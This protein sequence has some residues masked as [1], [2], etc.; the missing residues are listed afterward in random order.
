MWNTQK[1]HIF[2]DTNVLVLGVPQ[3]QLLTKTV[4]VDG[5]PEKLQATIDGLEVSRETNTSMKDNI[6]AAHLFDAQQ[7]KLEKLKDPTRPAWNFPRVHGIT[8]QRKK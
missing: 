6:V 1:C 4:C 8:R 5:L 2:G 3:A 7:E